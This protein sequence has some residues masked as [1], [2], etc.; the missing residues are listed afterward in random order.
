[1]KNWKSENSVKEFSSKLVPQDYFIYED[2]DLFQI[3][4][5]LI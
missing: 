4:L 3:N 1:M 5:L 2:V